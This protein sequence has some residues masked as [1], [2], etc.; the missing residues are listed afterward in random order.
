VLSCA[1][2]VWFHAAAPLENIALGGLIAFTVLGGAFIKPVRN[3][4]GLRTSAQSRA[5][6]L[7]LPWLVWSVIYGALRVVE[8]LRQ[9]EP[10][11]AWLEPQMALYGT[12]AH[13]WF[14]P[15]L[16][17][18]T[19]VMQSVDL[20][21]TRGLSATRIFGWA[22]V[23]ATPAFVW[24]E[25]NGPGK[26]L[27]QWFSVLPALGLGVL[28]RGVRPGD[29]GARRIVLLMRI[30]DAAAIAAAALLMPEHRY[31]LPKHIVGG[32]VVVSWL[33]FRPA[34]AFA[35]RL[36]AITLLVYLAHPLVLV[37]SDRI[38]HLD[39]RSAL[40]AA[41]LLIASFAFGWAIDAAT[42]IGAN[43][44]SRSTAHPATGSSA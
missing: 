18:A 24:L 30:V 40:V 10:A 21:K 35:L 19:L 29:A 9:G 13:L 44:L 39:I 4:Q 8:A 17:V 23:I 1:G 38:L 6:R 22:L 32:L 37:I 33:V 43:L 2:I 41:P 28:L 25:H 14:L 34:S 20:I 7:L 42:R 3:A 11:L 31:S 5:M 26:P 12:W 36:G 27:E 15:F 16:F